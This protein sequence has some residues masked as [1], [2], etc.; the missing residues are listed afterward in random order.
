MTSIPEKAIAPRRTLFAGFSVRIA[1]CITLVGCTQ[2][3]NTSIINAE[4]DE[5][6]LFAE[7]QSDVPLHHTLQLT[8][9]VHLMDELTVPVYATSAG[10]IE[11]VLLVEGDYAK[12]GQTL[13]TI[14]TTKAAALQRKL[15]DATRSLDIASHHR[16]ATQQ[17]AQAGLVSER[18]LKEAER[19]EAEAEGK[20]K[21]LQTEAEITGHVGSNLRQI[22][23]PINGFV[24][25]RNANPGMMVADDPLF[26][27][28]N[29]ERVW[30]DLY[31]YESDMA[32]LDV[33]SPVQLHF[34]ALPD[35]VVYGKIE[36]LSRTMDLDRKVLIA[37]VALDN[38]D[39]R[40]RPGMFVSGEVET[41]AL[42]SCSTVPSAAVIFDNGNHFVLLRM[43][44]S[45]AV[46]PV[47]VLRT[48]DTICQLSTPL[49]FGAQ[50]ATKHALLLYQKL[51]T[52]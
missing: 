33:G 12:R 45:V 13:A 38:R 48:T 27:I 3:A 21:Q 39:H 46:Q 26:T 44:D 16:E 37:R 20:L 32:Q 22:S 8:G 42:G 43:G 18:E 15:E 19:S 6:V 9:D 10:R 51:K 30:A 1:L 5:K 41:K 40:L 4:V 50:V 23:S 34:I 7:V 28:A 35:T 24:V 29:I 31:V 11:E 2:R 49:P 17:L 47:Q 36:R 52:Q 25:H 14:R